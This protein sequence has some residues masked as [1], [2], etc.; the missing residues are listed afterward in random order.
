LRAASIT[1][2]I[3]LAALA[4]ATTAMTTA[5]A[6]KTTARALQRALQAAAFARIEMGLTLALILSSLLCR[7]SFK[8][9]FEGLV[10]FRVKMECH[11]CL[12]PCLK[13]GV[14]G[15]VILALAYGSAY[16]KTQ[17]GPEGYVLVV[18]GDVS[19]LAGSDNIGAE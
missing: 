14:E 1:L 6:A 15:E 18:I 8:H 3:L 19:T 16:L 10:V 11:F 7:L 13:A 5:S 2:L 17:S 9:G 4:M 12:D